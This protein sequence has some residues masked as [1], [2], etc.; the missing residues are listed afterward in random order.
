LIWI[1]PGGE[2]A[3]ST[4]KIV[5]ILD[6]DDSRRFGLSGLFTKRSEPGEQAA[7]IDEADVQIAEAHD[8][9]TGLELSNANKFIHQRFTDAYKLAFPFDLAVAAD[10]TLGQKRRLDAQRPLPVRPNKQMSPDG[11][12]G[13]VRAEPGSEQSQQR[14]RDRLHIELLRTVGA[15]TASTSVASRAGRRSR[16]QHQKHPF[17]HILTQQPQASIYLTQ[18]PEASIFAA[19]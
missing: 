19:S 17:P 7:A 13:R 9:V 12:T 4:G 5:D 6:R 16:P 3:G 10:H 11:P 15:S 18:Q 1:N 14:S 2:L 8:V